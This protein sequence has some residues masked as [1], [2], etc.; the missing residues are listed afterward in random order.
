[1][2]KAPDDAKPSW[3]PFL[4][5]CFQLQRKT[6]VAVIVFSFVINLLMLTVPLYLLQIFNRVVPASTPS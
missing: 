1:M 4:R 5:S 2:V 3:N 6:F